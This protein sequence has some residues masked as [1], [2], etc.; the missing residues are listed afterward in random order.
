MLHSDNAYFIKH[1]RVTGQV[2]RTNYHPHTAFRGFGGPKGVAM[3]ERIIEKIAHAV[4]KDPLEVRKLNCYR[5]GDGCNVTH[6]GQIVENN[7]LPE[8][9]ERLEKTC[10]YK[11]RRTE[12]DEHNRALLS[13]PGTG[14]LV[15]GKS[16]KSIDATALMWAFFE[17]H[18]KP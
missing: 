1:M 8:L 7:C 14:T 15:L 5:D 11:R 10:D 16:T 4:G 2:C 9:L 18:S 13:A 6:Y 17:A 3:I 12:I